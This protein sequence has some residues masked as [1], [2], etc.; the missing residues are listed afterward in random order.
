MTEQENKELRYASDEDVQF[1]YK[2]ISGLPTLSGLNGS[3]KDKFGIPLPYG[4]GPHSVRCFRE[5]VDNVKPLKIFEIGTNMGWSAAVLLELAPKALMLSCDIS[6]K[7]ETTEAAKTLTERFNP[8]FTY[9][10]RLEGEFH[11]LMEF[12]KKAP[13]D[14]AFIDG[15]HLIDDVKADL[16][17]CLDLGITNI[18]MDDWLPEFGQVQEA[19]ATFG[20]Q[21]EVINVNGNIAL[22]KRKI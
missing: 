18:S 2:S 10:N 13:F 5:I 8:R 20:N 11:E 3:G 4:T 15:G 1:Y 22:L 6:Y 7:D 9:K 12:H 21:L 17:L 19:V 16:R 14:L